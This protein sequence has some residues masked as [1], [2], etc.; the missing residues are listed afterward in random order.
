[1]IKK[2]SLEIHK[3]RFTSFNPKRL[4]K[5]MIEISHEKHLQSKH[6]LHETPFLYQEWRDL[7]FL[8]W[9]FDAKK[10]QATLP[11]G[12]YVDTFQGDAYLSLV[13]FV[14]RNNRFFNIL[15]LPGLASFSEI[16]LRTYV[17]DKHGLPGVWFYS[18][19][20]D[21]HLMAFG[22]KNFFSL[23]YFNDPILF[24]HHHNNIEFKGKR[25]APPMEIDI[26]F[27]VK[28]NAPLPYAN[29]GNLDFFLVERYLLFV[30]A[31]G[32]LKIG[33][34]RHSPYP[35]CQVNLLTCETNLFQSHSFEHPERPP[36]H[37]QY[38]PGVDVEIFR[39]SSDSKYL[40]R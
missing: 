13:A 21:S 5:D 33:P 2:I 4:I 36:D 14:I 11:Q 26:R 31:A 20:I 29:F 6:A 39:L 37:I 22:G 18:L 32:M 3:T 23:P 40:K 28:N 1:M 38:S 34:V 10:I 7:I 17:Y 24:N 8:H 16:N 35:L 19:D 12:L 25:N 9:K 15:P 27:D 30:E